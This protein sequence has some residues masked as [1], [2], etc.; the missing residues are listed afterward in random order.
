M[1]TE[2]VAVKLKECKHDNVKEEKKGKTKQ[3]RKAEQQNMLKVV[4]VVPCESGLLLL[5]LLC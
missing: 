4:V 2:L 5:C 3:Q 1:P